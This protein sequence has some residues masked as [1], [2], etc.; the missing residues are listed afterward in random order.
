MAAGPKP[1][2]NSCKIPEDKGLMCLSQATIY[3]WM[4]VDPDK[5]FDN[6]R[7]ELLIITKD[8]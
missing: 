6:K 1:V 2:Q 8:F 7:Q 4:A 3:R 5:Y